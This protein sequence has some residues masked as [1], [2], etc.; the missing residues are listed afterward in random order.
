MDQARLRPAQVGASTAA[1][2]GGAFLAA[3][4]G[5]YGT[6]IG[7]GVITLMSTVGGEMLLRSLE[8][9]K[10]A[11]RT[12]SLR[13]R[14]SR[15]VISAGATPVAGDALDETATEE[16][17]I[18][19]DT[20]DKLDEAPTTEQPATAVLDTERPATTTLPDLPVGSDHQPSEPDDQPSNARRWPLIAGGFLVSFALALAVVA[21]IETFTGRSLNGDDSPTVVNVI[22]GAAQGTDDAPPAPATPTDEPPTSTQQDGATS[23]DDQEDGSSSQQDVEAPAESPSPDGDEEPAGTG[24]QAPPPDEGVTPSPDE[25]ETPAPDEDETPLPSGETPAP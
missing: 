8:R 13:P 15:T 25:E 10:Q 22:R 6:I 11:A 16:Q 9:T 7:V 24:E 19:A 21:G 17:T 23:P 12:A 3:R 20:A 5:V 2:V 14:T 1:A 18:A 4:L